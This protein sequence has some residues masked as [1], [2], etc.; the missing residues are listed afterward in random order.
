M[1]VD[2]KN[3]LEKCSHSKL[4]LPSLPSFTF[5]DLGGVLGLEDKDIRKYGNLLLQ[6]IASLN[7]LCQKSS[8]F[9]DKTKLFDATFKLDS[10]PCNRIFLLN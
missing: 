4:F 1:L 2:L 9:T 5:L 7:S 3:L 6:D 8:V 10:Y